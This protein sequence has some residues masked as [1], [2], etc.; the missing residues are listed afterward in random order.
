MTCLMRGPAE[1][2]SRVRGGDLPHQTLTPVSSQ[3]PLSLALLSTRTEEKHPEE[4]GF[5]TLK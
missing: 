3:L 2:L 5:L 4:H 1:Q